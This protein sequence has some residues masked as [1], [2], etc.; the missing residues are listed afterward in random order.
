MQCV[1]LYISKCYHFLNGFVDVRGGPL[2]ASYIGVFKI[3][4]VLVTLSLV[5][6]YDCLSMC[7]SSSVWMNGKY[8]S[9]HPK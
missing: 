6:T 7:N 5:G 1:I 4:V 3:E 8:I 2:G 9:L